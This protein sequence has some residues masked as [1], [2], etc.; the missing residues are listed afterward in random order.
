MIDLFNLPSALTM[1]VP[2]SLQETVHGIDTR[3]RFVYYPPTERWQVVKRVPAPFCYIEY[4]G[5]VSGWMV[6]TEFPELPSSGCVRNRLMCGMIASS[7]HD[8]KAGVRARVAALKAAG[9]DTGKSLTEAAIE[10]AYEP[11]KDLIHRSLTQRTMLPTA[12]GVP[13]KPKRNTSPIRWKA[14]A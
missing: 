9:D 14:T 3:M 6:V 7:G 4:Q 12:S 5:E 13:E 1:P 8:G 10:S 2:V 11:S